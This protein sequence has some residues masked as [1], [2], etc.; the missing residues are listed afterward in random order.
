[1]ENLSKDQYPQF[2]SSLN[3]NP[4]GE[5]GRLAR[6]LKQIIDKSTNTVVYCDGTKLEYK[7]PMVLI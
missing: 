6:K 7:T 4:F 5:D 3:F 2:I 1:M